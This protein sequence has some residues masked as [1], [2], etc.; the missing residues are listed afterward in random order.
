[1]ATDMDIDMDI[2]LG[3]MD[4]DLIID[5]TEAMTEGINVCSELNFHK[6]K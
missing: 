5:E 1:M 6:R 2:D 4:D 3:V